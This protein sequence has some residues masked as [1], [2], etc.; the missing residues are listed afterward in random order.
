MSKTRRLLIVVL[1]LSVAVLL[2]YY[3]LNRETGELD[4]AARRQLGPS[5]IKLR[6]GEVFYQLQGDAARP[7]VVLVHGFSIPSYL[8]DRTVEPLQAAGFRVLRFDLYGRGF[9]ARPDVDYG[10]DLYVQQLAELLD[11]LQLQ[12]PVHLVGL[13]M[14]GPIVSRF[15]HQ[16]AGRVA[17]VSLL[18]P[19]VQTPPRPEVKLLQWPLIGDYLATVALVPKVRN[20]LG[21]LVADP[22]SFPDWL[23]RFD[24]QSRFHGY[25]R[26]LLRTVRYLDGRDFV[27]DYRALAQTRL[28]LQVIWGENDRMVPFSQYQLLQPLLPGVPLQRIGNSGHLPQ[29]EHPQ[30]VNLLLRQFI[31]RHSRPD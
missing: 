25:A 6:Q 12:Q 8:W 30:Q 5:F 17:S 14:G 31:A 27:A 3:L 21:Q 2:P 1:L 28:P 15:A 29:Y 4:E 23:P 13:S 7:V 10:L 9:S 26:A 11:A 22:A 20:G 19:L 18:A 24:A 16:H